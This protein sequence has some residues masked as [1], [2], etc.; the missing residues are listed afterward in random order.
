VAV[1]KA[2]HGFGSLKA[3]LGVLSDVYSHHRVRL[4]RLDLNSLTNPS[5]EKH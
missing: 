2:P 4:Q 1:N 5:A 3:V